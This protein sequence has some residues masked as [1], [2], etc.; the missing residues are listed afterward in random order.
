MIIA[1]GRGPASDAVGTRRFLWPFFLLSLAAVAG[2]AA[3]APWRA[4][5]P[6]RPEMPLATSRIPT[7]HSETSPLGLK[8]LV[9]TREHAPLI[10]VQLAFLAGHA[11]DPTGKE[12][13]AW[14]AYRHVAEQAVTFADEQ[15][16]GALFGAGELPEMLVE[17]DGAR[18]GATVLPEDVESLLSS[19]AWAIET[20]TIDTASLARTV[21]EAAVT[22]A[23]R[24]AR[25]LTARSTIA[26]AVLGEDDELARPVKGTAGSRSSIT[27]EDVESFLARHLSPGSMAVVVAG[28]VEPSSISAIVDLHFGRWAAARAGKPLALLEGVVNGHP[29]TTRVDVEETPPIAALPEPGCDEDG[30][31]S[32]FLAAIRRL[33]RPLGRGA[34]PPVVEMP[35]LGSPRLIV[36]FGAPAAPSDATGE[37]ALRMAEQALGGALRWQL[38]EQAKVSYRVSHE[39]TLHQRGGL[40]SAS[41][42]ME[43][44]DVRA[45]EQ[46]ARRALVDAAQWLRR[47][48]GFE[49]VRRAALHALMVEMDTVCDL[50][51]ATARLFQRGLPSTHYRDVAMAIE[52]APLAP[53]ADVLE[54]LLDPEVARI[55]VIGGG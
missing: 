12:G 52:S 39:L 9:A 4:E 3:K 49:S 47:D 33:G 42:F 25:S 2:C 40:L 14:I 34:S 17:P 54:R 43:P 30:R 19:L 24:V 10:S 20:V 15:H 44:E 26:N 46:A 6:V 11:H 45:A 32:S 48:D 35:G 38:R 37:A 5:P 29:F 28:P 21:E 51:A 13:L 23:A 27:V 18:I 36:A 31:G 41:A 22:P 55:L 8:V 16:A 50:G 53:A 1:R 7:I